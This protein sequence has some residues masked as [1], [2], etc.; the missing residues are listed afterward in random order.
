MRLPLVLLLS[1]L[2]ASPAFA[3]TPAPARSS[4]APAATQRPAPPP[5]PAPIVVDRGGDAKA[6][7]ETFAKLIREFRPELATLYSPSAQVCTF[8]QETNKP[9]PTKIC[10]EGAKWS[11]MMAQTM[12]L[13]KVRGEVIEFTGIKV[14]P[15]PHETV[16]VTATRINRSNGFSAPFQMYI[17]RGTDGK[18]LIV[19]ELSVTRQAS[20]GR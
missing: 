3:T 6:F 12:P 8:R 11:S 14:E 9:A 16:K 2:I 20:T 15:Q 19:R 1:L 17:Q 10:V 13:S 5:A 4:T 7:F 18:W